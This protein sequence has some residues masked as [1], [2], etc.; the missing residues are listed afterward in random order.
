VDF[1]PIGKV[2]RDSIAYGWKNKSVMYVIFFGMVMFFSVQAFNMQWPVVFKDSYG[3]SVPMLGWIYAGISL[4]VIFGGQLS[5]KFSRFIGREKDSI[6]LSQAVTVAGMML[7]STML[8]VAPVLA[9][10]L[11]HEIGRG[12]VG[13][14]K[15]AYLNRRIPSD[16]RATIL[17]FDSMVIKGGGVLGL[18]VSGYLA[19]NYSISLAWL[20]SGIVLAVS[21][22]VFLKIK[23]GD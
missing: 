14:L 2:A 15:Q 20:V 21:I 5:S 10:F 7:A 12:M 13:P 16:R 17:S 4:F 9:G 6:I 3:L 18:I 19:K 1:K 8:G 22:P 11:V 23:N